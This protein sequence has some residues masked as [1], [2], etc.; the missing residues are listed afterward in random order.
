MAP[1]DREVGGANVFGE[2]MDFVDGQWIGFHRENTR[3][4]IVKWL[5]VDREDVIPVDQVLQSG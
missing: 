5:L 3:S 4:V 1:G 2:G